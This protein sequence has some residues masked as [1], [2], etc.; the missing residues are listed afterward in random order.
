MGPYPPPAWVAASPSCRDLGFLAPPLRPTL[1]QV[2]RAGHSP[3]PRGG[4]GL[5]PSA[6]RPVPSPTTHIH[7]GGG[8]QPEQQDGR[9]GAAG[10]GSYI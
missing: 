2:G 5:I 3:H 10:D 6:R 8:L 4:R 9:G 1:P 7:R